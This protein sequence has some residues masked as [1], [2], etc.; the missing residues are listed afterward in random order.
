MT[1][2]H[3]SNVANVAY[4]FAKILNAHASPAAVIC[5]DIKHVMSQPEW[6]DLP[7]DPADFPDEWDF[8]KNTADFG[9][10]RRPAWFTSE[11]IADPFA[12][13][14]PLHGRVR[15]WFGRRMSDDVRRRIEPAYH[16]ARR[17]QVR[18][19]QLLSSLWRP[20]ANGQPDASAV[21]GEAR[22]RE[23][24]GR[25]AALGPGWTMD[26]AALRRYLPHGAWLARHA[27]AHDVIFTYVLSPI[28]GM[29]YGR[30]PQISVEIGTMRD[31]AFGTSVAARLLWPGYRF[32]DHVVI[33]NPDNR[34]LADAAG[35]ESYSFCPHPLDDR[36]FTPGEE[37][38]LRRDLLA[39]HRVR[40]LLFAPA[41]QNWRIKGN[42]KLIRAFARLRQSGIDAA[43]LTPAWGQEVARSQALARDL[44]V[45][46]SVAWLPPMPEPLLARHYRAVDLVC[47]QF[48]LGVFGL[49]TPKAMACGA[50]VLTSYEPR[51]HA[52]C[53]AE[54]PPLARCSSEDDIVAA[55]TALLSN[56]HRRRTLGAAA[57][58]WIVAHHSPRVVVRALTDAMAIA[59]DRFARN[60]RNLRERA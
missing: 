32:S 55:A 10:Y 9:A 20:A 5:H 60:Q 45:S 53:F 22:L 52:W 1:S 2:L 11:T 54:D 24:V 27:A 14:G 36:M 47:D 28:Y 19:R 8:T 46:D 29:L 31:I 48:Q 12:E 34:D 38:E 7:L 57:R 39:R 51:H 37:P 58:G 49:I 40:A 35:L 59:S 6:D 13:V 23:V 17:A 50:P 44:G 3:V 15:G 18:V 4:G 25:G 42:D 41:R 16:R 30:K 56:E 21:N 33:T 43:L 26:A